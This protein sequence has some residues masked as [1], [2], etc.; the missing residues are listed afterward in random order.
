M[1]HT[2]HNLALAPTD[3]PA[4]V[5]D[6][7]SRV[8]LGLDGGSLDTFSTSLHKPVA[9]RKDSRSV[10]QI[11]SV[12][13]TGGSSMCGG[14]RAGTVA[15]ENCLSRYC[16]AAVDELDSSVASILT[17][18]AEFALWVPLQRARR[19]DCEMGENCTAAAVW[20]SPS[21][22]PEKKRTCWF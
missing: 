8:M 12:W 9:P 11:D 4:Q 14:S 16:S 10:R 5:Q 7:R 2:A 18:V 20:P 13:W 17:V 22:S 3:T 19:P 15:V 6:S 21:M 1:E